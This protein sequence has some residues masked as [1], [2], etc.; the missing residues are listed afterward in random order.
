MYK[1][2]FYSV[3][4]IALLLGG[5]Y[6]Y[7]KY[8]LKKHNLDITLNLEQ[9]LPV[10]F[11][12]EAIKDIALIMMIKNE[13]DIIFENLVWHFAVGFRKFVIVDNA[14]TDN[15]R[16]L[17]DKFVQVTKKHA[18]VIV[19]DDPITEYIQSRI[20]T[21]AYNFA[22][23]VWP[24]V[25]WIFPVDGD[26]FWSPETNMA[27]ILAK[28]PKDSM[29]VRVIQI[30]YRAA[31]DYFAFGEDEPFYHKLHYRNK[32]LQLN[33]QPKVTVR[34]VNNI[35][36]DQGNHGIT[37]L[38]CMKTNFLRKILIK[39]QLMKKHCINSNA[40]PGD[41]LGLNMRHFH[42][43]SVK[44]THKKY[45]NGMQANDLAIEKGYLTHGVGVHWSDYKEYLEKY[46]DQ[47]PNVKFKES[48]LDKAIAV[49]D[50]MPYEQAKEIFEQVI[51]N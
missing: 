15:T 9:K 17:I 10:T 23:S 50:P 12:K 33:S 48:F 20:T 6:V 3:F 19:V 40:F 43:R 42:V 37:A 8:L 45:F 47:A 7:Q 4:V 18:V 22:R 13:D 16:Q 29:Y 1:K 31:D 35:I 41:T 49:D 24:E 21:G 39:L 27:K 25:K 34:A 46:Q 38:S 5:N 32:T 51:S 44:Q 28:V 26:E 2:I 30:N 36:I 14:S 11:S